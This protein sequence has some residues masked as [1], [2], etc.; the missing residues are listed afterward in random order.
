MIFHHA[1]Y[2]MM[3]ISTKLGLLFCISLFFS[4]FGASAECTKT[5]SWSDDYPYSFKRQVTDRQPTGSSVEIVSLVFAK[6]NCQLRFVELPWARA[7]VELKEGRIDV[8]SN[9]YLRDERQDF[10]WYSQIEFHSPNILF[11]RN[12]DLR[13]Y[14][15]KSL[16]DIQKYQ[17]RIGTQI[18]VSYGL[19]FDAL[20]TQPTFSSLIETNSDRKA[21]WRMLQLKRIDGVIADKHTGL[22][23]LKQ[24]GLSHVIGLTELTIS[25]DAAHFAFSKKTTESLF[26]QAFDSELHTLL[27]SGVI[28]AIERKYE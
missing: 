26:V 27:Q 10:A 9:A 20:M 13:K 24:M 17:L 6:L 12:D 18:N 2:F 15:V 28:N 23:E 1:P 16:G 22:A 5:L 11:L 8:V 21:L 7:L 14:P 4:A 25:S 19:E 3:T